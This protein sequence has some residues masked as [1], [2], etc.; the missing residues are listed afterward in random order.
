[1]Y[2]FRT[3]SW[4]TSFFYSVLQQHSIHFLQTPYL[5]WS[6]KIFVFVRSKSRRF[7]EVVQP[8]AHSVCTF[9]HDTSDFSKRR[10][11]ASEFTHRITI[12]FKF[13]VDA[14]QTQDNSSMLGLWAVSTI[15]EPQAPTYQNG[16][17]GNIPRAR[18][19]SSRRGLSWNSSSNSS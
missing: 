12:S 5:Y 9:G 14:N 17:H 15:S 13:V 1:M 7:H 10:L 18:R 8:A 2:N 16:T 6:I 19:C 3:L 11:Q 4:I